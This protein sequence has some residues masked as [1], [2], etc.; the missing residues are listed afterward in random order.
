MIMQIKERFLPIENSTLKTLIAEL[1]SECENVNTL[2]HQLQ[3]PYLTDRQKA[4]ILAELIA[5]TIHLHVH[6][7]DDFQELISEEI[8]S[9]SDEDEE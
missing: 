5:A 2:I 1:N 3:S 4:E 6:C 7:G 9:L 8:E